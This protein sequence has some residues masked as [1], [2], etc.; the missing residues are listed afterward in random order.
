MPHLST[1]TSSRFGYAR[2]LSFVLPSMW[3][4]YLNWPHPLTSWDYRPDPRGFN[5]LADHAVLAERQMAE[6]MP[7]DTVYLTVVRHP[8][9]QLKSIFNFWKIP[10]VVF[11]SE[12]VENPVLEY[13]SDV[14]RYEAAYTS[15]EALGRY[16]VPDG[17]SMTKNLAAHCLGMPVGFPPG[18]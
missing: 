13:F 5:I 12:S 14:E 15:P 6:L 16:C 11:M 8:F 17:F 9:S 2:N 7:R 3:N 4:L 1:R 18:G 10:K